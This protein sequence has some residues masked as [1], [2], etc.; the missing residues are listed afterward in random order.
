MEERPKYAG[1]LQNSYDIRFGIDFLGMSQT[2]EQATKAKKK[3]INWSIHEIKSFCASKDTINRVKRQLTG[4]EKIFT[5][6]LF[7][8]GL[9]ASRH[10]RTLTT[11]QNKNQ[12]QF[13]N[14][15]RI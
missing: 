6:D 2:K 1:A 11:Q 15:Q 12:T 9:I 8:Q 3:K 10:K 4:W 13:K 5:S 14:G 7:H